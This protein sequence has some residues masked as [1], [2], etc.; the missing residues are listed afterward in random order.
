MRIP[1]VLPLF[2]A[3]ISLAAAGC[4]PG[5]QAAPATPPPQSGSPG[6]AGVPVATAAVVE[7]A[8]PLDLHV[9]GTAEPSAT[10]AVRS[11][12][13]GELMTVH[14]KEGDEVQQGQVL[15]VLD[16]RPFDTALKQA[17]A[18]LQRN[19]AL[20]ANARVQAK[21]FAD[22]AARGITARE[23]V[24]TSETNAAA[25]D[26]A[27][28][29]DRAAVESARNQLQDATVRAPLTGR[30]GA[31]MVHPGNLVRANDT[32]PLVVIHQ[33]TPIN[34]T[35]AIPES[36]LPNV[37]H[38][39]AR[40]DLRVEAGSAEDEMLASGRITF[41]DNAV[42]EA[43]GTIKLKGSFANRDGQL[44][45]GQFVNVVLKLTTEPKAVVVPTVAVQTGQQGQYAFVVKADQTVEL[46]PVT[47]A[48]T[49]GQET[50]IGKGLAPG[51]TVVTDGQL[52]LVAGSRVS[53]KAPV[54]QQNP[55]P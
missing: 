6:P 31:L 8:M 38:Y 23:Q 24:E 27:V 5:Q 16:R 55:L 35:F 33:V 14:F 10:V 51:E 32:T 34:V 53:L 43:S 25:L 30:T 18:N 52:R 45:P 2:S 40:G 3:L 37:R 48:R 7:K 28:A 22:L 54:P 12:I 20:A 4:G 50:I 13:T 11:P 26:A 49:S 36:Q 47:V 41:V 44:W 42:D 9:I 1:A 17:E 29:A 46:R 39:L 21:R 15:F 19:L